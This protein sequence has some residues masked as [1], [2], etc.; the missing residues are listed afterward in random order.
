MQTVGAFLGNP[1]SPRFPRVD[2]FPDVGGVGLELELERGIF[3]QVQGWALTHDGS[4]RDNGVEYVFDGA[5][6]GALALASIR[7]MGEHLRVADPRPSFRCSTHIHLDARD[8]DLG[9]VAKF[10]S[11]YCIMEDVMFDHCEE[12]RRFS[13]FC[14]PFMVN[15]TLIGS[16][17]SQLRYGLD[18]KDSWRSLS[19]YPKYSALNLQP[20]TRFGSIEFRGSHALT[21]PEDMIKLAQRMLHLKR[22][23][24]ESGDQSLGDFIERVNKMKPE[25]L[26]TS[27]LTQ[28]YT[29]GKEYS[30]I[31]YSNAI[32]VLSDIEGT[33]VLEAPDIPVPGGI[34]WEQNFIFD[35][36]IQL[37]QE[38]QRNVRCIPTGFARYGLQLPARG[39]MPL[40]VASRVWRALQNIEGIAAPAVETLFNLREFHGNVRD[41][42][43]QEIRRGE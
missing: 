21:D 3:G 13:N 7:A 34:G 30:D 36:G 23:V 32:K 11:A 43:I 37:A 2:Q 12:Y 19:R 20:L 42:V 26:F 31:C 27:G 15:D 14:V 17:T 41:E 1:G 9:Q 6:G 10:V 16:F 25:E 39:M 5:Q 28:G 33:K 35:G 24:M 29:R 22:T 38:P 40:A 4:L 18:S 8:F